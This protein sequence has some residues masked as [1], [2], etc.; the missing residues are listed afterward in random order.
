MFLRCLVMLVA[1]GLL[2]GCGG[3][4]PAPPSL[5]IALVSKAKGDPYFAACEQGAREA[6]RELGVQLYCESPLEKELLAQ[7]ELVDNLVNRGMDVI[8]IAPRDSMGMA[9]ALKRAKQNGVKVI[10]FDSD[11]DEKRSERAWFVRPVSDEALARSL[12]E[13]MAR[14]G[15]GQLRTVIVSGTTPMA[16]EQ[17]WIREMRNVIAAKHP[18]MQVVNIKRVEDDPSAAYRAMEE[19]L[20]GDRQIRGVFTL[21]PSALPAAAGAVQSGGFKDTVH[22]TGVCLPSLAR[23]YVDSGVVRAFLMWNPVDLGYLTVQVAK[24]LADG[25]LSP[26]AKEISAGRLGNR[27][28]RGSEVVLGDLIEVHAGNVKQFSF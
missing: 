17:V 27:S 13:L 20:Q 23:P 8:A 15:G 16:G 3:P 5:R 9:P 26:G 25:K 1:C 6:A 11:A 14:L 21:T 4:P 12:V 19:L 24:H 2:A 10:T 28:V 22:V 7:V 18:L